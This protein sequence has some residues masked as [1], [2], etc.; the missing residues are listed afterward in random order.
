MS[1]KSWFTFGAEAHVYLRPSQ[2]EKGDKMGARSKG[3]GGRYRY[4]GPDRLGSRGTSSKGSIIYDTL[5][6]RMSIER[7][8]SFDPRLERLLVMRPKQEDKDDSD[9]EEESKEEA[10]EPEKNI[11]HSDEPE[12]GGWTKIYTTAVEGETVRSVAR[13]LQ[14]DLQELCDHNEMGDQPPRPNDKMIKGT[15]LHPTPEGPTSF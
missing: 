2:R 1:N 11:V 9:E 15:E 12:P 14:I 4:F 7:N 3:G 5:E 10:N 8:C 13:R 6:H